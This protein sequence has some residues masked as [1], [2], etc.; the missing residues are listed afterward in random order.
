MGKGKMYI[1]DTAVTPIITA[2]S[3]YAKA[4]R[5]A[6]YIDELPD[7]VA[8]IAASRSITDQLGETFTDAEWNT[9]FADRSGY[10]TISRGAVVHFPEG[11]LADIV[12]AA[13]TTKRFTEFTRCRDS[14]NITITANA[15][16]SQG[17]NLSAFDNIT[18]TIAEGVVP[19]NTNQI[20]LNAVGQ[21]TVTLKG[22][23][24][25]VSVFTQM[26]QNSKFSKV[27][28]L[29]LSAATR[30]DNIFGNC[31]LLEVEIVGYIPLDLSISSLAPVG[32]IGGIKRESIMQFIEAYG[33]RPDKS[34]TLHLSM[35][36]TLR[37]MLTDED[38]ALAASYN[39]TL[40]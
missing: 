32:G 5:A 33:R 38:K 3:D 40:N 22:D 24:S 17:F 1:G 36:S 7:D 4:M 16:L 15:S 23:W 8:A 9:V 26:F 35:G 18:L 20:F 2:E 10:T 37:A 21:G 29:D 14:L 12:T 13:G 39:L 27:V 31:A 11:Y 34:T 25:G 19:T 6:G 28:G 30:V